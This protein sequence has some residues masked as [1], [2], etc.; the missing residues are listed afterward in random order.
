MSARGIK[1]GSWLE[2]VNC[3]I[4]GLLWAAGTQRHMRWHLLAAVAVLLAAALYKVSPLEFILLTL[5]IILV[6]LAEM[7][8]TSVEVVVDMVSPEFHPLARR[9]K[10]V[11]A[12]AV[13]TASFGAAVIG[14]VVLSRPVFDHLGFALEALGRMPGELAILSGLTVILLVVLLKSRSGRG[15]PL[16]GGMPSGHSAVA[17]SIATS[18]V[19]SGVG[20]VLGVL[21]LAM[22]AMVSQ[23]RLLVKIHSLR[24]VIAGALLGVGVTFLFHLLFA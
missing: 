10:D 14:Y 19:L 2:S 16:H 17:F 7:I 9:A 18:I 24:E 8:N 3:A 5:A 23:S 6:L 11:A 15:T 12:G 4:E 13:L 20:P 1:P 21:A 22:A